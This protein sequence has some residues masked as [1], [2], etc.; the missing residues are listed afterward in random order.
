VRDQSALSWIA[1]W[2]SSRLAG[3]NTDAIVQIVPV[4]TDKC[5]VDQCAS[6]HDEQQCLPPPSRTSCP[7][8]PHWLL[9]HGETPSGKNADR[10][11]GGSLI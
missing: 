4:G 10:F 9:V 7:T 2:R 1:A 5:E 11:D 3:R 8:T 6:D